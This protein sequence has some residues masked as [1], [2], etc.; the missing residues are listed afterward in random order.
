MIQVTPQMRVLVAVEPV[1]FRRGMDGL[2]R[3]CRDVLQR[4][5]MSGVVFAFRNRRGTSVRLLTFDGQGFWLATKRLSSG[6]FPCWPR[7]SGATST[8]EAHE[9]MVLLQG[10]NP[11]TARGVPKWRPLSLPA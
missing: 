6:R 2:A 8:L 4:D 11:D 10:G 9:L 5:P 7:A 3:L 1:D